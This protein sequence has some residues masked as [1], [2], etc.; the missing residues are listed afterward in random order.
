[1]YMCKEHTFFFTF[2]L[3]TLVSTRVFDLFLFD[4]FLCTILVH[5]LLL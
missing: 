1:M 5:V 3:L 4:L 2:L